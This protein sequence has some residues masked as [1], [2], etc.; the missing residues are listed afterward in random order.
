[1]DLNP[2]E[3]LASREAQKIKRSR[4]RAALRRMKEKAARIY[5]WYDK[6]VTLADHIKNCSCTMCGNPR[7]HFGEI[8]GQEEI[9]ELEYEEQLKEL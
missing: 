2:N 5:P 4:R 8:T 3:E 1:M 9:N 7:R 6:A